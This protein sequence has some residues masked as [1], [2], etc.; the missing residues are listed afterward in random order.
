VVL[1][2]NAEN[3]VHPLHECA[4]S[5]DGS[6]CAGGWRE[7]LEGRWRDAPGLVVVAV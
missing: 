6:D 3:A 7:L 1:A 5:L 2:P 4:A